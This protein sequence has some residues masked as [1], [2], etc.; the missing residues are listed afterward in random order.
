[1]KLKKVIVTGFKSIKGTEPLIIDKK[2]TIFIGA[3]DH[4]K[5]N[6]LHA[7]LC[8]NDDKPITE[9]NVN[10]DL[11]TNTKPRIEWHFSIE[12]DKEAIKKLA[13]PLTAS[14]SPSKSVSSEPVVESEVAPEPPDPAKESMPRNEDMV[15]SFYREGVGGP[16]QVL[17]VP[18]DIPRGNEPE[19][20]KL[21]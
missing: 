13:N 5:S 2:T 17:S 20:L 16:V 6:L 7:A 1:M 21:S 3:N 9:E 4:G 8:L 12:E 11:D 19:L 15:L 10:W 14:T 18:Y